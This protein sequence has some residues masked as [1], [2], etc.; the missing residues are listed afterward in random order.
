MVRELRQSQPIS[1]AAAKSYNSARRSGHGKLIL[2][3]NRIGG[4]L[5]SEKSEKEFD[6]VAVRNQL[7]FGWDNVEKAKSP[8]S[9]IHTGEK[10]KGSGKNKSKWK[11][12]F[13]LITQTASKNL[14]LI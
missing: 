2:G 13:R 1:F 3:F 12:R 14:F 7:Q 10:P 6:G 8:K 9:I 11:L 5:S 4:L